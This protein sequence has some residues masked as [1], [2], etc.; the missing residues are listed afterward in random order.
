MWDCVNGR[1]HSIASSGLVLDSQRASTS[2]ERLSERRSSIL[3]S[4][5]AGQK[6][7]SVRRLVAAAASQ[8]A[9]WYRHVAAAQEVR[10]TVQ[11]NGS[12]HRI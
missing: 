3:H 2:L 10:E 11:A 4:F 12:R 7:A 1:E 5:G 6:A 9:E 8:C